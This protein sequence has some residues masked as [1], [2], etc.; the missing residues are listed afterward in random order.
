MYGSEKVNNCICQHNI[1]LQNK[2]NTCNCI[3]NA[4]A[5]LTILKKN[6]FVHH[7]LSMMPKYD[8]LDC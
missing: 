8:Y 1:Q 6:I 4:A 3:R 5:F 7:L 2:Q